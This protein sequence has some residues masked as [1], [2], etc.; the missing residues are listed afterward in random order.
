MFLYILEEIAA[1]ACPSDSSEDAFS[2][3]VENHLLK[4]CMNQGEDKASTSTMR[5]NL[6]D[7]KRV[8]M[9]ALLSKV[10]KV[11]SKWYMHYANNRQYLAFEG[12]MGFCK[13]FEIYPSLVA[14]SKL[15]LI[16]H[17]LSSIAEEMNL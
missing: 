15:H 6:R 7:L 4:I 8:D 5:S 9:H 2:K 10:Q 11:F 12:F 17:T 1:K 13:D 14:K 16:F 3:F